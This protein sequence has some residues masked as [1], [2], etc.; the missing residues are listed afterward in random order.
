VED[1]PGRNTPGSVPIDAPIL[2]TQGEADP[3]VSPTVQRQF[4]DRLCQTANIVD[5]RTYP[6]VGHITIAHET[7]PAVGQWIAD[8]FAGRPAP[9][10]CP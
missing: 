2:I 10:T 8:R 3:I 7:V 4:A 6:G 9:S 1:H 5:Y